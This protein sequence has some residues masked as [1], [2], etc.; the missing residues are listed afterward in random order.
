MRPPPASSVEAAAPSLGRPLDADNRDL[1]PVDDWPRGGRLWTTSQTSAARLQRQPGRGVP[2]EHPLDRLHDLG[3]GNTVDRGAQAGIHDAT[4]PPASDPGEPARHQ[5]Q[6][7]PP[8][9]PAHQQHQGQRHD[10]PGGWVADHLVQLGPAD[11]D[12]QRQPEHAGHRG[13]SQHELGQPDH[14]PPDRCPGVQRGPDDRAVEGVTQR[15]AGRVRR[16]LHGIGPRV[17]QGHARAVGQPAGGEVDRSARRRA[18]W[19]QGRAAEHGA[20]VGVGDPD[21]AAVEPQPAQRLRPQPVHP[22][23]ER[24][25]GARGRLHPVV[26]VDGR[27]HGGDPG[28]AGKRVEQLTAGGIV[29]GGFPLRDVPGQ[30]ARGRPDVAGEPGTAHGATGHGVGQR[31]AAARRGPPRW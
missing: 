14:P 26:A 29:D 21:V 15:R 31:A 7:Q 28:A 27:D 10:A 23:G 24:P 9:H 18:R 4:T 5:G 11:E 2:L 13:G 17:R 16:A 19:G 1:D 22:P 25:P 30:R 6:E 8:E 20:H 3:R 12:V